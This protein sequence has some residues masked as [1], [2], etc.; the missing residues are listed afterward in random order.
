MLLEFLL[1][2]QKQNKTKKKTSRH[3]FE[4]N[5]D[6][7]WVAGGTPRETPFS[8]SSLS[9]DNSPILSGG[10]FLHRTKEEVE[11]MAFKVALMFKSQ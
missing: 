6:I 9:K 2:K 4:I 8:S 1:K 3:R 10:Y 5:A 7:E 11:Q